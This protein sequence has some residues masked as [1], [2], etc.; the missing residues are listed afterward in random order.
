MT[1]WYYEPP[2]GF[3]PEQG[4]SIIGRPI[5]TRFDPPQGSGEVI[6]VFNDVSYVSGG[7]RGSSAYVNSGDKGKVDYQDVI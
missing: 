7:D 4:L 6:D 5:T 2:Q 1:I 3:S